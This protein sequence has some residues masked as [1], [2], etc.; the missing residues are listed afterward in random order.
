MSS[1]PH[2]HELN[3]EKDLSRFLFYYWNLR[4]LHEHLNF[5]IGIEGY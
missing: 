3:L 4:L 1:Q 5:P 2:F